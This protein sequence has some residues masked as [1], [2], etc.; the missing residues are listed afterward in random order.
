MRDARVRWALQRRSPTTG[1]ATR[2][3]QLPDSRLASGP[4]LVTVAFGID[5]GPDGDRPLRAP[6]PVRL[7][8]AA[9]T[10]RQ[11]DLVAT[12]RVGIAYAPAPWLQNEWRFVDASSPS[13]SGPLRGR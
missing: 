12:P 4:G 2:L 13:V 3:R 9:P 11:P 5:R 6:S 1:T 10:D 7:E 8:A